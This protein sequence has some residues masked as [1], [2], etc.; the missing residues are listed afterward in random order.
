MTSQS[1]VTWKYTNPNTCLPEDCQLMK[2]HSFPVE[3]VVFVIKY[4]TADL[5]SSR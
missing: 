1:V 4:L 2:F 3:H 5:E